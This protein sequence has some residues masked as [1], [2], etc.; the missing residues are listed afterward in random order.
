MHNEYWIIIILIIIE[1]SLTFS[2]SLPVSF[3]FEDL[4]FSLWLYSWH[5]LWAIWLR[6]LSFSLN[7]SFYPSATLNHSSKF[8]FDFQCSLFIVQSLFIFLIFRISLGNKLL[9]TLSSNPRFCLRSS[10]YNGNRGKTKL[11]FSS[12]MRTKRF[13][14]QQTSEGSS[15]Q[16]ASIVR[17]ELFLPFYSLEQSEAGLQA[18]IS[19]SLS[20]T[21]R[22]FCLMLS[23]SPALFSL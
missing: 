4:L 20:S 15:H 19:S 11:N 7:R 18:L 5:S 9:Y 2:S 3:A 8:I 22:Q 14:F 21:R 13:G 16:Q 17:D 6:T 10:R 23:I 12:K 1:L